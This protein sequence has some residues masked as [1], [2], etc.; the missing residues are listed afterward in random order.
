[1]YNEPTMQ[2]WPSSYYSDGPVYSSLKVSLFA[3]IYEME[4]T[5]AHLAQIAQQ[6]AAVKQR[7]LEENCD[8]LEKILET[9][10]QT[11]P[12]QFENPEGD[13]VLVKLL[14]EYTVALQDLV[15]VIHSIF[16]SQKDNSRQTRVATSKSKVTKV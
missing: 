15:T 7:W 16:L 10:T 8:F 1:M 3:R 5:L 6:D 12:I 13:P 4:S 14:V 11:D 9:V 2:S